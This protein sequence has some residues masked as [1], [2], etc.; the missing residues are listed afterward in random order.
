[1]ASKAFERAEEIFRMKADGES[2]RSIASK[3]NL[4]ASSVHYVLKQGNDNGES[5]ESVQVDQVALLER[6]DHV[7]VRLDE[8]Q[9]RLEE[10]CWHLD[11]GWKKVD[12]WLAHRT[13]NV[14]EALQELLGRKR[15]SDLARTILFR[16]AAVAF[17]VWVWSVDGHYWMY[18]ACAIGAALGFLE[19][20]RSEWKQRLSRSWWRGARKDPFEAIRKTFFEPGQD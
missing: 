7:E 13:V 8:L 4:P 6:L 9:A 12:G 20:N 18:L 14:Q 11:P 3:L 1:M 17:F 15:M 19:W 16:A 5:K 10:V 2:V